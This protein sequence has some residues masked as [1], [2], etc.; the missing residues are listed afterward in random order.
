MGE[1][2]YMYSAVLTADEAIRYLRLDTMGLKNPQLTL[3][4]YRRSGRLRGTQVS[5]RVVYLQ[6]ELDRF[7]RRL[8]DENPR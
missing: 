2:E 7:L 6:E 3:D 5:K 8:T 4:R 1:T